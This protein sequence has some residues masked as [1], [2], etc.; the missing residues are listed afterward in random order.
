MINNTAQRQ[1]QPRPA[2]RHRQQVRPVRRYETTYEGG[3]NRH[4]RMRYEALA[5]AWPRFFGRFRWT[6]MVSLTFDPRRAF[7]VGRDRATR[8]AV[9]WCNVL[10]YTWR[11]PVAWI[12][13]AECGANGKWHVHVL[14]I[15]AD[16]SQVEVVAALWRARN[17]QVVAKAVY[18]GAGAALYT[19]K[20]NATCGEVVIA[21]SLVGYTGETAEPLAP[22]PVVTLFR[23]GEVN[24]TAR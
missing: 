24:A 4:S 12:V 1:R 9:L 23:D 10:S 6:V 21:D 13:A 11:R 5:A 7:K 16:Q 2:R 15:G 19:T 17:G 8:E 18:D 14:V 22:K 20:D 3:S